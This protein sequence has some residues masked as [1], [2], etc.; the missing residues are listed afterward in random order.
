MQTK[1]KEMDFLFFGNGF[2][3]CNQFVW[4]I[5]QYCTNADD[6]LLYLIYFNSL[7]LSF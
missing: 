2:G 7:M 3:K 1:Q 5:V 6:N 4:L